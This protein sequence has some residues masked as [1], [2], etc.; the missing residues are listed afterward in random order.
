MRRAPSAVR[1]A[2]SA[3]NFWLVTTLAATVLIQS[4]PNLV[5]IIIMTRSRSS[6]NMGH[7]GSKTRSLGQLKEKSLDLQILHIF[8]PIMAKLA[9]NDQ[10]DKL[11]A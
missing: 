8:S 2:P 7:M 4:S 10:L 1:R 3:V 6:S 5:R 11:K 9:Q